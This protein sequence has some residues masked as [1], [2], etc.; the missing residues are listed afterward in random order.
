[1]GYLFSDIGYFI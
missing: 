1:L